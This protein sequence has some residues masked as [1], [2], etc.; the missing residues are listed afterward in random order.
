[1][2]AQQVIEINPL[3]EYPV[4]P[5][6]MESLQDKCNYLVKNFWNN[7]DFKNKQ[8]IDQYALNA[9]FQVYTTTFRFA[10]K[11]QV[12]DSVDKLIKNLS[13]SAGMLQQFVKAA[14]ENL[15]GPRAEIWVDEIY[16]KFLDAFNNNKKIPANRK[17]KYI[18]QA[19][20]LRESSVGNTAPKFWFTDAERASKQYFP[21]STPTVLIFGNPDDTDWRIARL[22]ME[23][24]F[25]LSDALEKGKVNILYIIPNDMENWANAISNYNKYWT[26]GVSDGI[27]KTYDIR[28]NPTI[29]LI[30]PD[31]KIINKNLTEDNAVEQVLELV[32]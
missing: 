24:N 14:E 31:G 10:E 20:S 13:S 23:S 30:G 7:F 18:D 32:N 5:E 27:A 29:Y 2:Q 11:K 25:A 9:A 8:P 12:D 22:K 4:A 16:L 17:A 28:L 1:M 15:Y 19:N 26:L 3:F 6:E 21:M